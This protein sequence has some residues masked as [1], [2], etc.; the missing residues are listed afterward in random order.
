MTIQ[1]RRSRR[2][3]AGLLTVALAGALL[4]AA[5]QAQV[6]NLAGFRANLPWEAT[7]TRSVPRVPVAA[8]GW[9]AEY[10]YRVLS[11]VAR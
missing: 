3:A 6:R 8:L 4:P 1:G 7:L 11:G 9:A 10:L 2:A 5:A